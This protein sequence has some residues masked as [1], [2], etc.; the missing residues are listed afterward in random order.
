MNLSHWKSNILTTHYLDQGTLGNIQWFSNSFGKLKFGASFFFLLNK[1]NETHCCIES[2]TVVLITPPELLLVVFTY[3]LLML[4]LLQ[5]QTFSTFPS[6]NVIWYIWEIKPP[7]FMEKML[8]LKESL[9]I[10]QGMPKILRG[11]KKKKK[12]KGKPY[13]PNSF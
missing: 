9:I 11:G 5:P 10:P 1:K 4:R 12:E 7:Q 2:G 3:S 13:L 8:N 6:W